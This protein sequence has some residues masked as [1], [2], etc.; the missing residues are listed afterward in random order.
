MVLAQYLLALDELLQEVRK[1][2]N[3]ERKGKQNPSHVFRTRTCG[4]S[5]PS[6][7]LRLTSSCRK[8]AKKRTKKEREN[9]TPATYLGRV[10]A[11]GPRPVPPCAWRAPAGST[12][13]KE[14]RK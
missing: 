6:T 9:K 12:Q 3:K 5:S 10:P 14:Q 4:W 1:E 8:Y 2:K 11:D 13:R 7:S